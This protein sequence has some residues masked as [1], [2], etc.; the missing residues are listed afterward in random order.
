MADS[1]WYETDPAS[2][3]SDRYTNFEAADEAARR[4]V[5]DGAD[6]VAVVRRT[7]TTLRRYRRQVTVTSEDIAPAT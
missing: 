7:A 5:A 6:C 1:E 3:T 2:Q 4:L